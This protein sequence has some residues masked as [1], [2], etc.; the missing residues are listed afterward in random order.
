MF[1]KRQGIVV[2]IACSSAFFASCAGKVTGGGSLI[3]AN[4]RATIAVTATSC[5]GTTKGQFE[6]VDQ[7]NDVKLHGQVVGAGQCV[8][9]YTS[10]E[11]QALVPGFGLGF[12]D[13]QVGG[14]YVSQ[15]GPG[16]FI[17]CVSDN[18][19]GSKKTA[20]DRGSIHV[21]TGPYAGYNNAGVI[22]GNIQQHKCPGNTPQ[23]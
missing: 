6:Y 16:T 8:E 10:C 14:T 11:C 5:G 17:A 2:L 3:G 15:N 21:L 12:A 19:E 7:A 22:Q 13:Y 23:P 18:G 1:M 9:G 20:A 4:G